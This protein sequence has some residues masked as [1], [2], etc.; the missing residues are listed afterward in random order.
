MQA[1][2]SLHLVLLGMERLMVLR[3]MKWGR[4][5]QAAQDHD[6]QDLTQ[7]LPSVK[8]NCTLVTLGKTS[9]DSQ[10]CRKGWKFVPGNWQQ[11][12]DDT[13]QG[14]CQVRYQLPASMGLRSSRMEPME[15]WSQA[16]R[17]ENQVTRRNPQLEVERGR[18]KGS[19]VV[20]GIF[21]YSLWKGEKP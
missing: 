2:L 5:I 16:D 6:C 10:V 18:T 4:G 17:L 12:T 1:V 8:G 21:R 7:T 20:V 15:G 13:Y 9:Q 19:D 14:S 3:M 11:E